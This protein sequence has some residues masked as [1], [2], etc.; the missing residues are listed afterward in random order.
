VV[1]H[2]NDVLSAEPLDEDGVAARYKVTPRTVRRWREMRTGPDWF[3]ASEGRNVRYRLVD[4]I[5]WE[6]DRVLKA[7][8]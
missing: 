3:Y 2:E 7:A 1:S 4:L 6:K 8:S 5:A